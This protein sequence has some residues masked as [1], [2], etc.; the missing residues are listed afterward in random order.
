MAT[1]TDITRALFGHLAA[2]TL[3][4]AHPVAWPN[5]QFTPPADGRFLRAN[6]VPA[7]NTA[8]AV[9]HDGVNDM[10]GL[11]QVDVFGP[12]AEG[13]EAQRLAASAVA[14]HFKRGTT[15]FFSAGRIEVR[16]AVVGGGIQSDG[17]YMIPVTVN[18]RVFAL[19]A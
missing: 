5:V 9:A 2:L 13:V 17:R 6:D 10:R 12:L 11:L 1:E 14:A 8:L 3:S 4:P 19:N 16:S 15:F 7:T 18:Y